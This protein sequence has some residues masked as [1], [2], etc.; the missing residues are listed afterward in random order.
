[1]LCRLK[2]ASEDDEN[3][4]IV[5]DG[6]HKNTLVVDPNRR[7]NKDNELMQFSFDHVIPSDASQSDVFV[8]VKPIVEDALLGYNSTVFTYGQTGSGTHTT[9]ARDICVEYISFFLR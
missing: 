3:D 7:D 6:D 4:F 9:L 1:M 2:P 5:V 8:V